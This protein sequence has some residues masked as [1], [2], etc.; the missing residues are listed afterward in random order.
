MVTLVVGLL[1]YVRLIVD[2]L[3]ESVMEEEGSH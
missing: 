2:L 3:R 1:L